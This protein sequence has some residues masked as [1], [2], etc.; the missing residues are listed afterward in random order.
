MKKKVLIWSTAPWVG[1]GYGR[2]CAELI[3]ALREDYDVTVLATYGLTGSEVLWEGIR[4]LPSNNDFF[5]MGDYARKIYDVEKPDIIIQHFDIWVIRPGFLMD[6]KFPCP[7]VTYTPVDS[8]PCP[9]AVVQSAE[10]AT[11]NIAMS[12]F[13]QKEFLNAGMVS[14]TVIHHCASDTFFPM[15]K[16]SCRKELGLP[17]DSFIIGSV[18]TNKGPRK[19]LFGQLRAFSMFLKKHPD[20]FF[21]LHC[22]ENSDRTHRESFDITQAIEYLGLEGHIFFT[23]AWHYDQGLSN[24]MM[25]KLYNCFDLLSECSFGEGA[26]LPIL[27]AQ[28][29]GV[30]VVGTNFSAIPEMLPFCTPLLVDVMDYIVWQNLGVFHAV[31]STED[32]YKKY[33]TAFS[34]S[35]G[36]LELAAKDKASRH[37]FLHWKN[38]WLSFLT[39][40]L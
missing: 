35:P 7:V 3:K 21:Y 39:N 23:E 30:P 6:L 18:A 14:S 25:C 1:T 37:S 34:Y 2:N 27:E 8:I 31:P 40:L 9:N 4:V 29:C 28:A 5:S 10:G 33:E 36:I 16:K 26:G 38:D 19:N 24:A 20:S 13:A 22:N 11:D 32:I 15:D 12:C 17:L